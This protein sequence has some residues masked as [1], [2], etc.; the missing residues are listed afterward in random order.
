MTFSNADPDFVLDRGEAM[1]ITKEELRQVVREELKRA[2][3]MVLEAKTTVTAIEKGLYYSDGQDGLL[4]SH[5]KAAHRR[6]SA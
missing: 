4:L 3:L 2:I 1:S 6:K 5:N